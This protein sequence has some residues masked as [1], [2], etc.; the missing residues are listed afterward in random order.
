MGASPDQIAATGIQPLA[1]RVLGEIVNPT[2]LVLA[3]TTQGTATAISSGFTVQP[4]S[5]ASSQTGGILPNHNIGRSVTVSNLSSTSSTIYPPVGGQINGLSANTG[6]AVAANKS[7][8]F[9]ALSMTAGVTSYSA[10]VSA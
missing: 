1:A 4:V 6:V 10:N 5:A 2:T 9:V 8:L 7:A 3:G